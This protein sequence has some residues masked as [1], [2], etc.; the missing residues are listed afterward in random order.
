MQVRMTMSGGLSGRLVRLAVLAA[1]AVVA[2]TVATTGVAHANTTRILRNANTGRCLDDRPSESMRSASCDGS[3]YQLWIAETVYSPV[4]DFSG[5]VTGLCVDDSLTYG[6]RAY[7]CNGQTFQLWR[8]TWYG[9][10]AELRN[11]NTGR[12]MDDSTAHKLR[13]IACNG[14]SYQRWHL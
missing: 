2:M 5:Y 12:C 1:L 3:S 4:D 11:V 7:G 13:A 8:V 10:W 6:L 9:A 14:T